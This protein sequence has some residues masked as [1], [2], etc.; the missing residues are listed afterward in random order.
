MSDQ[1]AGAGRVK[2]SSW[3]VVLVLLD[4]VAAFLSF[5]AA[6]GYLILKALNDQQSALMRVM[7]VAARWSYY[8]GIHEL[9]GMPRDYMSLR[10]FGNPPFANAYLIVMAALHLVTAA[11]MV[12][13]A[14]GLVRFRAWARRMHLLVATLALVILG[15]YAYVLVMAPAHYW[16]GLGVIAGLAVVPVMV[17]AI[18]LAPGMATL[19]AEDLP[20]GDPGAGRAEVRVKIRFR[21]FLTMLLALYVLGALVIVLFS[22][23]PIA[24]CFL[25][26]PAP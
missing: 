26:A 20:A 16:V 10:N 4:Y 9:P 12:T 19:F 8:L 3:L 24:L 5:A 17:F 1:P 25:L 6:G 7:E 21:L 23:V 15:A 18:L 14:I 22:S 2:Q 13:L 11:G